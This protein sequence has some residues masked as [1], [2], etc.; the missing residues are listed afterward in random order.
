MVGPVTAIDEG[1]A[2]CAPFL[3]R[4]PA[5][6][7]SIVVVSGAGAQSTVGTTDT[8][9][10]RLDQLQFE[11]GEGPTPD[12]LLLGQPVLTPDLRAAD[13]RNGWPLFGEAAVAV[14][15]DGMF[16]FPM[17]VGVLTV[18]VVSM[19]SGT[20]QQPWTA[21]ALQTAAGLTAAAVIPAL[22][23]AARSAAQH[24]R[25]PRA[26]TA[27][28]R[29]EVHQASG[30]LTVQL[31]CSIEESL[32]LLRAYAFAHARPIDAVARDIVGRTL[33]LGAEDE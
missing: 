33:D 21:A 14:G 19:Y 3:R 10:A 1:A 23:L 32:S 2:L 31:D 7:L 26:R 27:E 4:L 18:G 5:D 12:V 22:E 15:A 30:M 16:S 24:E 25:D 6:G 17:L 11:L 13:V 29:R 20:V 28:L 9:A 8:V